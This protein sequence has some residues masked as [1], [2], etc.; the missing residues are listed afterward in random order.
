ML[1]SEERGL[2]LARDGRG[3]SVSPRVRVFSRLSFGGLL[4]RGLAVRA[5]ARC[6]AAAV[7][8]AVG[9]IWLMPVSVAQAAVTGTCTESGTTMVTVTSPV[10]LTHANAGIDT[11]GRV[12]LKPA[13]VSGAETRGKR[14]S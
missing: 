11:V 8:A 4:R 12:R 13:C 9:G 7:G 6:G 10:R 1:M 2:V 14:L 3:V 5:R